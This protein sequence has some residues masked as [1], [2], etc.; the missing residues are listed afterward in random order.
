MFFSLCL[1]SEEEQTVSWFLS[2]ES[3]EKWSFVPPPLLTVVSFTWSTGCVSF[4]SPGL[5]LKVSSRLLLY[6]TCSTSDAAH[7]VSTTRIQVK[8]FLQ[9][10]ELFM[11]VHLDNQL[12]SN[13]RGHPVEGSPKSC[14]NNSYI[15]SNLTRTSTK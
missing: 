12:S 6:S 3:G 13:H 15:F 8:C 14:L 1:C 5:L 7:Q 10:I 4:Q 9:V 2:G 11:F